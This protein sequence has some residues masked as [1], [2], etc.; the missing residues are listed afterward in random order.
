MPDQRV[1]AWLSSLGLSQYAAAFDAHEIDWD[2]LPD[3]CESDLEKVGVALGHRKKILRAIHQALHSDGPVGN[4]GG[5]ASDGTGA[6]RAKTPSSARSAPT[7]D[8]PNLDQP[9]GTE[10]RAER[11][12]LTVMF[13]DMVGSTE[14]ARR[15]DPEDMLEILKRYQRT[16]AGHV[17]EFGGSIAQYLGD[18]ILAYFGYPQAHENDAERAVRA[19]L[20]IIDAIGPLNAVLERRNHV[21]V[22]V[23]IGIATG[24]VVVGNIV[25]EAGAEERTAIGETP[26]LAARLQSLAPG[27]S[28]II[29][30]G[31]HR[32][33]A[34]RF[35]CKDLGC[36]PLAGFVTPERVWQVLRVKDAY[37]RLEASRRTAQDTPFVGRDSELALLL[38]RWQQARH[39]AGQVVLVCG[40]PG[41]GKSRLSVA[42]EERVSATPHGSAQY[43]GSPFRRNS[44][45]HPIIEH[46]TRAANF[47]DR[48]DEP[49]RL[50]K[51][52]RVL[53]DDRQNGEHALPL[54]TSLLSLRVE[55][56]QSDAQMSSQKQKNLTIEALVSRLA[57]AARTVP[58]IVFFED[59]Q[60]F[61]PTSLEFFD[62]LVRRGAHLPIMVLATFRPEFTSPWETLP[63]VTA[64]TLKRLSR[65]QTEAFVRA[66]LGGKTMPDALFTQIVAK[67]SGVPLFVEELT[68]TVLDS[69][70]VRAEANRYVLDGPLPQRAIPST[71]HDSLMARLDQLALPKDIAQIGSVV[72]RRFSYE[73]LAKVTA[74][75]DAVLRESLERLVAS[76]LVFCRGAPPTS[77]YAFKH[78]LIQD[79]AYESLLISKRRHLH[80]RTAVVLEDSFPEAARSSPEL[81]AH[82]F[83]ESGDGTRATAYWLKAAEKASRASAYRESVNHLMRGLSAIESLPDGRERTVL[84]L[85]L[86]LPLGA[87][88][89]ALNGAGSPEVEAVYARSLELCA[90][91]PESPLHFA[92]F[93]GWWRI[94]MDFRTGRERAD[95]LLTLAEGL[96]DPSLV[97]QAHHSLWATNF[98][99]GDHQECLQHIDRGLALYD[100][101]EHPI[102]S[103]IYAGHDTKVCGDG[104]AALSLWLLGQHQQ[105]DERIRSAA[106]WARRLDDAGSIAH[107]LDYAV[108]LNRYRRRAD[109]V[110]RLADEMIRFAE[111][112]GL[113]DYIAKGRLFRGWAT[114]MLGDTPAGVKD[115]I[116]GLKNQTAN[117]TPEDFPVYY[118]MLAEVFYAARRFEDGL[119]QIE[120]ALAVAARSGICYWD[121]ELHRRKGAL[122]LSM[123]EFH[124]AEAEVCFER[125]LAVAQAQGARMLEL[126]AATQLAQLWQR[127]ARPAAAKALLKPLFEQLVEQ[128]GPDELRETR[129]VFANLD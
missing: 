74:L 123:G 80:H 69:G 3:L 56:S 110:A 61:D 53:G 108:V 46:L 6:A 51:L 40:E 70:L 97:L 10:S 2:V 122:L 129:A 72:G 105:A 66:I 98:M 128:C 12:Q 18:G 45:L 77:V 11:R 8:R 17:A 62:L 57:D 102:L 5:V 92:A 34:A 95:R 50:G 99:L 71:I 125:A 103:S 82:H 35:E 20:G 63:H 96:H 117:G 79:A 87:A 30:D 124:A 58:Q 88:L 1:D 121:A 89:M 25:G 94:S 32:L 48:D 22:A 86:R 16:C 64:I 106:A 14:M 44:A 39:G 76:G 111:D 36:L 118:D 55:G 83:T 37:S 38:D 93:W 42:F 81:I 26:N 29:A 47:D 15:L 84:E 4:A 19:A 68:K 73:L 13:C 60:W 43:C 120:E 59:L 119:S 54:L 113:S 126:N 28:V 24:L 27:N 107:A 116:E 104:E 127:Q 33:L 109:E 9:V 21:T 31:T 7:T 85:E 65:R 41:I 23:R 49:T 78:A 112:R 67:T 100:A 115:L 101:N 91:L 52:R 75:P 114:A 90:R